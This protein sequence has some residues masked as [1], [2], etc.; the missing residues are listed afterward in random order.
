[1]ANPIPPLPL[2]TMLYG[3]RYE[4]VSVLGAGGF[5]YVYLVQDKSGQRYALKQ[6][7]D[8]SADALMQFGQEITVQKM[9]NHPN[10]ARIF[11]GFT[12]KL[13]GAIPP[14]DPSYA[15]VVM[16]YV[17]GEPLDDLL[18]ARMN[19][20]L[21]PFN[22]VES[23]AWITQLLDALNYIHTFPQKII[24]RDI[25]PS[26][27]MVLP[28]GRTLKVIDF[29]IAKIGGTGS[30][31]QKG[32]R[33]VSPGYSPPEQYSQAGKTDTFSDIYASGATLY[34][35][36]TG[37][38]PLEATTRISGQDL[39]PPRRVNSRISSRVESVILKAMEMEVVN[40]FQ[41]AGEMLAALQGKVVAPTS[42]KA[43]AA[44][45][46]A[47]PHC[48]Q[49][50]KSGAKFCP[51][52]GRSPDPFQFHK[53]GVAAKNIREFILAC[54][55]YWQEAIGYLGTGQIEDWL[56]MQGA[57]GMRLAQALQQATYQYPNDIGAQLDTVLQAADPSRPQPQMQVQPP[58]S[59]TISLEEG[60]SHSATFT[61]TNTGKGYLHGPI[62]P[63]DPWITVRPS[64]IQ[65]ISGQKQTF[66][67]VIDSTTLSGT[68]TG[69]PHVA[70][71]HLQT[72]GGS[73]AITLPFQVTATPKLDVS[74]TKLDFGKVQFG[75]TPS[76][77]IRVR[78]GGSGT[79]TVQV[80][81]E[82]PWLQVSPATLTLTR[83]A[84][85]TVDVQIASRVL[86]LR[87]EHKAT[88]RL[89]GGAEGALDVQ[90]ATTIQGPASLS[91]A[92]GV[93]I[94]EVEDLC[95]WCDNHWG[96][97]VALL[98]RGEMLAVASYLGAGK[99]K[100]SL[101]GNQQGWTDALNTLQQSATIRNDSIALETALRALG[102][103]PPKWRHN[104]SELESKLGM[105]LVPDPRWFLPW[106][107][108][109]KQIVF[110]V[111]NQGPRGYLYGSLASLVPW[112]SL[113]AGEFGCFPGQ[114]AEITLWIDKSKRDLKGWSQALFDLVITE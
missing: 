92:P 101:W 35:L 88:L 8:L 67:L 63:G 110:R 85:Q 27:L 42:Q 61:V 15:F 89:D 68:R 37:Q 46:Q 5:G 102:A 98:R 83:Q 40:R 45:T 87:G 14:N 56:R 77:Q 104:W 72:N 34:H 10:L 112:I 69:R 70:S 96:E 62:I 53:A 84:Q 111:E 113:S 55:K 6:N 90:I 71:I 22:E 86:A 29:G 20:G 32:A 82:S 114:A 36:L 76:Q 1:M 73:P 30:L 91:H 51:S 28:N 81:P 16:E 105:G 106:W 109:P 7:L 52:C 26:N 66:T 54:D 43:A 17:E 99:A 58:K 57:D 79:L 4:V 59:Q 80:Q 3:N 39:I 44:Q 23:V 74:V 13:P 64:A 18:V 25:K 100:T 11:D 19:Q 95:H 33:G 75:Q 21:G 103:K 60:D 48:S 12:A 38:P 41:S 24:H 107:E 31:T 93:K 65:C 2:K 47:C 78:N 97:G 50:M 94:D 108:G 49:Q 9:L